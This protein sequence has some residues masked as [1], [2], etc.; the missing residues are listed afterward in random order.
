MTKNRFEIKNLVA[1]CYSDNHNY[2]T[3]RNASK[4]RSLTIDAS[5]GTWSYNQFKNI[6]IGESRENYNNPHGVI[7]VYDRTVIDHL[8]SMVSDAIESVD[9]RLDE[10]DD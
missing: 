6:K 1:L 5:R 8:D 7:G 4:V 2:C 10:D 9:E 3:V